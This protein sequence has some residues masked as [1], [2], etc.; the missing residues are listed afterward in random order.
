MACDLQILREV[1]LFALLDDD[2]LAVLAE[3]VELEQFRA[4]PAHLPDRT[5]PLAMPTWS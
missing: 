3:Q 4:A 5:T 1:P 2:E